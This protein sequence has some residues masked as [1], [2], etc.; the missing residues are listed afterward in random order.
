MIFDRTQTD[1]DAAIE[2]I[3]RLKKDETL[4][5]DDISQL[6][7][8]TLTINTLNRI[9]NKQ[10]ELK[11]LLNGIGYWNINVVNRTWDYT[12][13]FKQ[14]DFNRIIENVHSLKKAFFVYANTPEIT[15]NDYRKY[16]TINTVEKNLHDL[17]TMLNFVKSNFRQC[18][19]FMCGEV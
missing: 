2:L 3:E 18:G 16:E 17:E 14:S 8:G 5:D 10:A 7:R 15:D 13:Y 9:E 19:T 1:V 11:V 12:D 4:T 6:E